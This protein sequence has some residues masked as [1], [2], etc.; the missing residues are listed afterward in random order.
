MTDKMK[1]YNTIDASNAQNNQYG[2]SHQQTIN[3]GT[4]G[5]V[6]GPGANADV[7]GT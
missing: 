2:G 7:R 6:V 3:N 1:K 5:A 4:I